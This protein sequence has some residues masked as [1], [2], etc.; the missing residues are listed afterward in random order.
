MLKSKWYRW[1][2]LFGVSSLMAITGGG[3][4]IE[5]VLNSVLGIVTGA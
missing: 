2:G 3:C 5:D 4:A 1:A